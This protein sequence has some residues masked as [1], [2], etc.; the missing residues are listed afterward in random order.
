[1]KT[2]TKSEEETIAFAREVG[3]RL[4]MGSILCFFGDLAAGKTTFVKGIAGSMGVN[5]NHVNSPTFVYLNQYEGD[6]P[7]YHFDLYRLEDSKQFLG[8]GFDEYL[9]GDGIVCIEWSERI[10]DLLPENVIQVHIKHVGEGVR[11]IRIQGL[12]NE[13]S[14]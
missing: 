1:M 7:L 3:G 4:P 10:V 2:V 6:N 14:V 13:L 9:F 8:M 11:E 12:K 5:P